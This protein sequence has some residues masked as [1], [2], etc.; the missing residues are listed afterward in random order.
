MI[1]AF[2]KVDHS[3]ATLVDKAIAWWTSG[4]KA[5]F[6]SE[7]KRATLILRLFFQMGL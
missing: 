1:V 6:N 5:K 3:G 4:F 2:Y 7:W